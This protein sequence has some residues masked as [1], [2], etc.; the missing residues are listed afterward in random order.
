MGKNQEVHLEQEGVQ[1]VVKDCS[2]FVQK[3]DR[4]TAAVDRLTAAIERLVNLRSINME[5]TQGLDIEAFD[6]R[7]EQSLRRVLRQ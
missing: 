6:V 7:V 2:D 4:A 1:L 3:I 5:V